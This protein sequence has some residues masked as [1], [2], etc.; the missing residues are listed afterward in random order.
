MSAA[1]PPPA[2]GLSP[3]SHATGR[4]RQKRATGAPG[5]DVALVDGWLATGPRGQ[6]V[7]AVSLVLRQCGL[8]DE[9]LHTAGLNNKEAKRLR[10]AQTSPCDSLWR[11][12][13]VT[14]T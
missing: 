9:A 5:A 4:R 6:E 1:A 8:S 12:A 3:R 13:D 11:V 2:A 14:V 10:G 7:E